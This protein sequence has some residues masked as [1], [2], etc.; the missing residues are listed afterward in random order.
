MLDATNQ[1][2]CVQNTCLLNRMKSNYA[3]KLKNR[4]RHVTTEAGQERK[5]E[6]KL[7]LVN[8]IE[9]RKKGTK[10]KKGRIMFVCC[11]YVFVVRERE[12]KRKQKRGS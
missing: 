6:N 5:R 7:T 2:F 10:E 8:E 3:S 9:E 12:R 4:C 11:I 1:V